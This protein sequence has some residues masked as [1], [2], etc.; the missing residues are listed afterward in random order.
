MKTFESAFKSIGIRNHEF[1]P[2]NKGIW[3]RILRFGTLGLGEGY[4][5]GW[6]KSND[7]VSFYRKLIQHEKRLKRIIRLQPALLLAA[8]Q[9]K[10]F[11]LQSKTLSKRDVQSHYD[12]GQELF[13]RMLDPELLMYTCGFFPRSDMSLQ[14]AQVAKLALVAQK[15]R[16]S[17]G[18][19][20][21]IVD[22]GS[23]WGGALKY[24]NEAYGVSGMGITLAKDQVAVS[25]SRF[26]RAGTR[27]ELIDYRDLPGSITKPFD[28]GY[29]IGMFEHIGPKNYR[30]FFEVLKQVIK[31]GGLFVLHT[32]GTHQTTHK[33]FDPFLR[34][35]I[36][37]NAH[38]SSLK[39]MVSA[40][41][42][43]MRVLD[44]HEFGPYYAITLSKWQERLMNAWPELEAIDS[45]LYTASYRRMWEVY[46]S[47]VEAAF[48]EEKNT[49]F[50]LVLSNGAP[51]G[52]VYHGGWA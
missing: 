9:A 43:N 26:R 28:A 31:P 17:P 8:I 36:F 20:Q 51:A 44:I 29:S 10:L 6:W 37:G 15:L 18:S 32:I 35:H 52:G 1:N 14:E 19:R 41:E 25:Q 2:L 21:H 13:D 7:L 45:T 42:G 22:I 46:L 3:N 33:G 11:N 38:I 50:Q 34:K 39:E 23:G 49:L 27:Y 47:M 12:A 5:E 4:I 30:E 48:K 40:S 16:L 24:M